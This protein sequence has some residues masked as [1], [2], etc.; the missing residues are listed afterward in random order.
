MTT[1]TPDTPDTDTSTL[2]G[3]AGSMTTET[4]TVIDFSS[5]AIEREQFLDRLPQRW[6]LIAGVVGGSLA[7]STTATV[8]ANVIARRR[9]ALGKVYGF[10]PIR[11]FGLRRLETPRG[12]A[13]WL[14]YMYRTPDLRMRLPIHK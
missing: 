2:S 13:A 5:V 3:K 10:R 6:W 9:A 8:V 7:L 4:P 1:L 14:A 12:G 11:R